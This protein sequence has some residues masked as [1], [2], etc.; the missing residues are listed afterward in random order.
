MFPLRPENVTER[1]SNL[2]PLL[3]TFAFQRP[4]RFLI[5][6]FFALFD[7]FSGSSPPFLFACVIAGSAY[8]IAE[9]RLDGKINRSRAK[10]HARTSGRKAE[11]TLKSVR[12]SHIP[13]YASTFF[14][15]FLAT[16]LATPVSIPISRAGSW[17]IFSSYPEIFRTLLKLKTSSWDT[18]GMRTRS[19][20]DALPTTAYTPAEYD[21]FLIRFGSAWVRAVSLATAVFI[22]FPRRRS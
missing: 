17:D 11:A 20:Y 4:G 6:S 13:R 7:T 22:S 1:R 10:R 9:D 14:F 15:F 18:S 12:I 16:T 5:F 8:A 21:W 3:D 2:A 19:R